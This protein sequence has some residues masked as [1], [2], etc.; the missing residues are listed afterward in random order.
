MFFKFCPSKQSPPPN[1]LPTPSSL[2][3][4]IGSSC[5]CCPGNP[6]WN[7]F[8]VFQWFGSWAEFR[9]APRLAHLP[10][11]AYFM[12]T[13]GIYTSHIDICQVKSL[14]LQKSTFQVQSK[15]TLF[16]I[17]LSVAHPTKS[18]IS[19]QPLARFPW[20]VTRWPFLVCQHQTKSS[21]WSTSMA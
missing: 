13:A 4:M 10:G 18:K 9:L 2:A 6:N 5:S 7:P 11:L 1:P 21:L 14:Y 16:P 19:W 12:Y 8:G 20:I 17:S 15:L 3:A